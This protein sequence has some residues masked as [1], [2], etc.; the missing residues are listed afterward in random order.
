[1]AFIQRLFPATLTLGL[2][3]ASTLP[4][5]ATP[6]VVY[7][8]DTLGRLRTATY[9][10]GKQIVYTYDPAGNRSSVVAQVTPHAAAVV[11]SPHK[12]RA[13]RAK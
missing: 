10:N 5:M 11:P 2:A 4:V 8:Y 6:G 7:G 13:R 12:K 1:M 9:D 3:M